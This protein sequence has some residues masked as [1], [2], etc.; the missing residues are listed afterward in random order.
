MRSVIFRCPRWMFGVL[1]AGAIAPLAMI[2]LIPTVGWPVAT[3]WI[4]GGVAVV[5]VMYAL[6]LLPTQL[7]ISDDG[8]WQKLL[9]SELR[10]RW[11]D[12]VEWR[13]C[14]GGAEF[15]EGEMRDRTKN[16]LHSTEFWVRDK[17]GKKHHFKRWLV[18]GRR[19]KQVAEIMRERGIEGG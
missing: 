19:S 12:V 3:A 8:I 5:M 14:D 11:E 9:C 13:H 16:R 7:V 18:F 4:I 17:A 15:E 1:V 10:L 6:A 2:P